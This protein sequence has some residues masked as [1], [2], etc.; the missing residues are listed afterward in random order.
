M[1]AGTND[2]LKSLSPFRV[3]SV[4]AGP[5]LLLSGWQSH[6]PSQAALRR[7][8]SGKAGQDACLRYLAQFSQDTKWLLSEETAQWLNRRFRYEAGRGPV[9]VLRP[10]MRLAADSTLRFYQP[11]VR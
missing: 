2:L 8:L 6:D 11:L 9:V 1:M 10:G 4:G 7:Q 5:V 3:Y